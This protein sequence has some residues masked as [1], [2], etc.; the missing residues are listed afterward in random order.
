METVNKNTASINDRKTAK[1]Y[2][3]NITSLIR[4]KMSDE[5]KT[6]LKK[7]EYKIELIVDKNTFAD[8]IIK[9]FS[10]NF[11]YHWNTENITFTLEAKSINHLINY[12]TLKNDCKD[13]HEYNEQVLDELYLAMEKLANEHQKAKSLIMISDKK[14]IN[15]IITHFEKT[16]SHYLKG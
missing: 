2:L 11:N 8:E 13:I 15:K 3:A 14:D 1:Q 10:T 7:K 16:F 12:N 5:Y 9:L 4:G 6:K